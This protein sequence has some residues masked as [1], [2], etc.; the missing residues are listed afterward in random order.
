MT[1]QLTVLLKPE[2]LAE[3]KRAAEI[4]E[5]SV[6]HVVRRTLRQH[7]LPPPAPTAER[8]DDHVVAA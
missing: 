2:L 4:E 7:F 3:L 5:V 1:A 8:R 6:S